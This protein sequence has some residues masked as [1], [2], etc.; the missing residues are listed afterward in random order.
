[1][2]SQEEDRGTTSRAS[3]S[4][5]WCGLAGGLVAGAVL[6]ASSGPARLAPEFPRGFLGLADNETDPDAEYHRECA[7]FGENCWMSRC[8]KNP[9]HTCFMKD[10]MWAG[11]MSECIPGV[12]KSDT[13]KVQTPWSCYIVPMHGEVL[14]KPDMVSDTTRPLI[15]DEALDNDL[16]I[17]F[18]TFPTLFCFVVIRSKT[19]EFS[20]AE[21][22]YA[23]KGGIFQ[24]E[25][26]SV[27]SDHRAELSPGVSTTVLGD[28][29]T[30]SGKDTHFANADVFTRAFDLLR[31]EERMMTRDFVVK[32]DPDAVF[33]PFVLKREILRHTTGDS[34]PNIYFKNCDFQ[35]QLWMFGAVEVLSSAAVKAYFEGRDSVCRSG[36]EYDKMGEDTFLSKCLDLLGVEAVK[37]LD[38]LA[39]GYCNE[40]PGSCNTNQV[41]YHP[42]KDRASWAACFRSATNAA[43][44][45][46]VVAL[47]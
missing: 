14:P 22:Q 5:V 26:W 23:L 41:A 43:R 25:E 19:Y 29:T 40:A 32:V 24:C 6:L 9:R 36:L 35:H 30:G 21:E 2:A 37:D 33:M 7:E 12:Q 42:F 10:G 3:R 47:K 1:V 17:E 46:R 18:G 11:C 16:S 28:L 39:D 4:H 27:L 8:C 34:A 45:E 44:W 15:R 31:L 38:L 13:A 20:L